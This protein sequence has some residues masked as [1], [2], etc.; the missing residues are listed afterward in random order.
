[1]CASVSL[2][3]NALNLFEINID[4]PISIS[5]GVYTYPFESN[6]PT[7]LPTSCEGK[8]GFIR[9]FASV[10]IVRPSLPIQIQTVPF[11]VIKPY[12]LNAVPIFQV[13]SCFVSLF[14]NF[15]FIVVFAVPYH[16]VLSL[17]LILN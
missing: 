9:Y 3:I 6:L 8:Y 15:V 2:F 16:Q 4:K 1:M 7:N 14:Y 17:N 13:H 11:T 10:H 12:N 5:P